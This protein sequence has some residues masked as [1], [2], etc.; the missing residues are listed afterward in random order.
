MSQRTKDWPP[1]LYQKSIIENEDMLNKLI[2]KKIKPSVTAEVEAISQ[3]L[4]RLESQLSSNIPTTLWI[5]DLHGEGDRFKSIL[6]GRFGLLYQTCK[7]ALPKTFSDEKVQYLARV[8]RKHHFFKDDTIKMDIQDILLCLT[9]VIR[10]KLSNI[11]YKVEDVIL[12]EFREYIVRMISG[13]PVP[14]KLFEEEIISNRLVYHLSH[15]IQQ[16]LLDGIVVLG[17]IFDRGPQPD[18]IIRILA[19]RHYHHLVRYVYG[20]HDILWVGAVS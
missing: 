4:L 11:H 6:R 14:D 5:S 3:K 16:I 17:D 12:P 2:I 9:Q 15:T 19:S 10:Y 18:K 7:E 1:I 13:M 20:N 8:I